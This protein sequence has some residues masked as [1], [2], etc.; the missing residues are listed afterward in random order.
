MKAVNKALSA[1]TLGASMLLAAS[2]AFAQEA[3]Y[4]VT[5]TNL[6]AGQVFS[7]VLA[8]SHWKDVSLFELGE[9]ASE[10]LAALAEG[11]ATQP[12]IDAFAGNI[13]V[14][15]A[16]VSDGP[17]PPGETVTIMVPINQG[18]RISIASML[19]NTNDAFV[20]LDTVPAYSNDTKKFLALAYDA[21]SE[22]NDELCVHIPGPACADMGNERGGE[23]GEEGEGFVHIHR[24]IH[25]I[26]ELDDSMTDWR[27]PVAKVT[28]TIVR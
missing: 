3:M 23:L 5:V 14:R 20:A 2:G 7:P 27:N 6:T 4:K 9:E 10:P 19:V 12:L 16:A 24:G 25:G 15:G 17:V 21:G 18:G 28:I 11:G 8:V 26:G 13:R 1:A 22:L